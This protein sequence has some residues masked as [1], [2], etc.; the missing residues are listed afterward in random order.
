M[1]D[2]I[3]LGQTRGLKSRTRKA[4]GRMQRTNGVIY[5]ARPQSGGS[6][7]FGGKVYARQHI[8]TIDNERVGEDTKEG[9]YSWKKINV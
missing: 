7:Y 4:N 6:L 5:R 2:T 8:T 3:C 9:S 1:E